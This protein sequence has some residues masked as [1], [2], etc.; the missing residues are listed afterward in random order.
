MQAPIGI[1]DSGIGGLT[2]AKAI[3]QMLPQ[4]KL[5]YFGDTKNMPY[6]ARSADEII[7]N[8]VKIT[9]FLLEKK[10]KMIIIACNSASAN[11][12]SYLR[13]NFHKEVEI[14]G[15]I[16][17][18]IEE[19]VKREYKNIGIIGT[20][21]TISSKVYDDIFE[22]LSY[23]LEINSLAC[24]KLAQFIEEG[25]AAQEIDKL[26]SQYLSIPAFQNIEALLLA[27]THYPLVKNKIDNFFK[28]KVEILDNAAFIAKNVQSYLQESK[29]LANEQVGDDEFY[30]SKITNSFKEN[31]T[32]FFQEE[33]EIKEVNL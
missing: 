2:A 23:I 15:V 33:I 11:A 24:P 25:R 14:R 6:G 13:K 5:I 4:E 29:L 27:C 32:L 18:M 22:E 10:V 9:N 12:A 7:E 8:S 28:G 19:V 31:A 26:L 30:V 3:K 16:R 1:F 21:A 20:T 17:P